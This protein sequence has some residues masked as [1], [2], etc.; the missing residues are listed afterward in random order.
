MGTDREVRVPDIGGFE[1]VEIIDVLVAP[2]D[3]VKPEDPLITL[4]SDKAT[5]DVPAPNAGIVQDLKVH[6]GD[7]VSQGVLILT[8]AESPSDRQQAEPKTEPAPAPEQSPQLAPPSMPQAPTESAGGSA[9][10]L[11]VRVPDIGGFENVPVIEVLV[12]AGDHVA[13][14]DPLITLESDK[15]TMDVPAPQGGTVTG[16]HVAVGDE[17]SQGS[18][19]VSLAPEVQAAAAVAPA[20][21][22][23]MPSE[24]PIPALDAGSAPAAKS[25]APAPTQMRVHQP[26]PSLPPPV[27][28]AG[29]ALPHASPSVRYLAREFGVELSQ[30]RG[31][32]PK[33][34]IL[35]SDVQAFVKSELSKTG[36]G[37]GKVAIPTMPEIDFSEFGTVDIQD[38]PRIKK[39]AGAHLHRAWL[40]IPHVTHHEEADVTEMEDFRKSLKEDAE[41]QG[42][43][44]TGLL[45]LMKALV[46]AMREFPLFNA[47]LTPDGQRLVY[48]KYFHI[49]IATDTPRGLLVPVV[50]DVDKKGIWELAAE[51]GEMSARAREGKLGADELRGGCMSIS[52]LGGIG[53]TAFTPI[54]N[55]PEVAILGISR[56]RMQPIWNGEEFV[57]RLMMPLDLSYDHRVV[58]GA[59]AARFSA[60]LCEVL[61]DVRRMLL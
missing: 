33:G 25:A 43:R 16:L 11:E 2:G 35:K 24:K 9:V 61:G 59:E 45:F 60:F 13:P 14:E 41:K 8:L 40:T 49:G 21:Q 27:E 47:S 42:V 20:G 17:V 30:V 48:K 32:G 19:I 55:A 51:T 39:I 44:V 34:R 57:P 23:G 22:E 37:G 1:D 46:A 18:L 5:M 38:L 50:R 10:G 6:V 12:A 29:G 28:K 7:K 36:E 54:V 56:A 53:G 31:S 4:E 15:A 58:D 52:N 3:A 26:P